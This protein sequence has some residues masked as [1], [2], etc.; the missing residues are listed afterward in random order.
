[1]ALIVGSALVTVLA[2]WA[3]DDSG[4]A[5]A[6]SGASSSA[7]R[8]PVWFGSARDRAVTHPPVDQSAAVAGCMHTFRR[9]GF[10][11]NVRVNVDCSGI[12]QVEEWIAVNPTDH[13][14]VV[15]SHNDGVKVGM[16]YSLSGSPNQ[17]QFQSKLNLDTMSTALLTKFLSE[18]SLSTASEKFLLQ[19]QPP[20]DIKTFNSGFFNFR[21]A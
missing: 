15:V 7:A 12:D 10:P 8:L 2:A 14:N 13:R 17:Y 4:A 6:E 16:D 9:P 18:V 3:L 1:M 20:T 11:D 5:A 21:F 19:L